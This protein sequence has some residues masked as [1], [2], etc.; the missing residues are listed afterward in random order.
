MAVTFLSRHDLGLP[1]VGDRHDAAGTTR[2]YPW[3][4]DAASFRGLVA[5]HTVMVL[6]DWDRDGHRFGD[7]DDIGA[8]MR[9]LA[10]VRT[11]E[12]GP[13]VPY[14]AVVI[15]DERDPAHAF[16]CEGR[17]PGR[18][19]AH[20]A[21]LNSSRYGVAFEGNTS[22]RGLLTPGEV[23]AFAW[24]G[25]NWLT[26]DEPMATTGHRDHKSTECPGSGAYQAL[27]LLQPPFE[28]GG[29]TVADADRVIEALNTSLKQVEDRLSVRIRDSE[30]RQNARILAALSQEADELAELIAGRAEGHAGGTTLTRADVVAAVRE[31]FADAGDG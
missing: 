27:D 11:A 28:I 8:F 16:V 18:V 3:P 31:V 6:D 15:R 1:P 10:D 9:R 19:G 25:A 23:E 17:G 13:E 2:A 24:V 5:H 26:V 30:G 20:T 22:D 7:L 4:K 21:G 29:L 12:L 14:S